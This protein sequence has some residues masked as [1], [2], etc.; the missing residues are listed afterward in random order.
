MCPCAYIPVAVR[1]NVQM[2]R[3]SLNQSTV[4]CLSLD[5]ID[6]QR[7]YACLQVACLDLLHIRGQV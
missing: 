4:H 5:E 6:I 7:S 1:S 3:K 2:L